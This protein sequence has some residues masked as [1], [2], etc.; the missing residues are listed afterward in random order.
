[1]KDVLNITQA[2][3]DEQRIRM[4]LA[5]RGGELCLCQ[6][7]ELLG[8]ANSTV[9]KHLSILRQAD[10]VE[11]RREGRWIYCKLPKGKGGHGVVGALQWVL[12]HAGK[13]LQAKADSTRLAE[14]LKESPE[15][16]C[17]RQC[18]A[19]SKISASACC[20]SAP[21]TRVAAR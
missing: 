20:S 2:L 19:K 13:T 14:I 8:L 12:A 15:E 11:A 10:L 21:A 1:M 18:K 9:S 7:T 17:R 16:I 4:L 3:A 6:L 5:L